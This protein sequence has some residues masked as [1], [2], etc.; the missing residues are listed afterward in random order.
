M[1]VIHGEFDINNKWDRSMITRYPAMEKDYKDALKKHPDDE[2]LL[3]GY[4][5]IASWN[6][7]VT[8]YIE[9]VNDRY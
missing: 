1:G 5:R 2:V 8:F 3:Y 6:Q 9:M 7:L 4:T